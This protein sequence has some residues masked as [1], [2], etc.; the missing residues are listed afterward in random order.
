MYNDEDRSF[1]A[2]NGTVH[3]KGLCD[4]RPTD[5]SSRIHHCRLTEHTDF[6]STRLSLCSGVRLHKSD[7]QI[8]T[9]SPHSCPSAGSSRAHYVGQRDC[10]CP[11]E[12]R[13]MEQRASG[14]IVLWNDPTGE[15]AQPVHEV[16]SSFVPAVKAVLR[17]CSRPC[18]PRPRVKPGDS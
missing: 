5:S 11:V 7:P 4:S 18:R 9:R 8:T 15:S 16:E 3:C 12:C 14:V 6:E 17:S 1:G 13:S 10:G 2:I